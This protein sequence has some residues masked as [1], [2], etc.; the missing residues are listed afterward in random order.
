MRSACAARASPKS[1]IFTSPF[2]ETM[3]LGGV[4]SR[5]TIPSGVPSASV[6]VWAK[7]SPRQTWRPT[8]ATKA[9]DSCSLGLSM[10]RFSSQAM[11]IPSTGSITR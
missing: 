4:T 2:H 1:R 3:M 7:S 9:G 5:W 6:R 8:S 10:R 11:S